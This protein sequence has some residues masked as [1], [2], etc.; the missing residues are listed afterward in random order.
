MRSLGRVLF[1]A[2]LCLLA[3]PV[4]A[5]ND[6]DAAR[7]VGTWHEYRPSDNVITFTADG[8]VVLYLRKGEV[9]DR[10]TLEGTWSLARDGM[11][12]V[13]LSASRGPVTMRTNLRFAGGEMILTDEQ[14]HQMYHERHNGPLPDWTHW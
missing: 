6:G 1:V 2:F 12:T 3:A 10:R 11:L 4:V 5:Q 14:G 13:T 7:L 8:H 9:G